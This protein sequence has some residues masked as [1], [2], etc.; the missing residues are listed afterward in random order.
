M[1]LSSE[2]IKAAIAWHYRYDEQCPLVAF[3]ANCRLEPWTGERADLLVVTKDRHLVEVEIKCSIADLRADRKKSKH[4]RFR[5]G[6]GGMPTHLFYFAFRKE[7]ANRALAVCDKL[8]PYAGVWGVSVV[9]GAYSNV[10]GWS[11]FSE[12][13]RRPRVLSQER[14]SI[15]KIVRMSMEQSGTLCRL[16]KLKA[17]AEAGMD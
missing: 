13:Y 1:K 9:K 4:Q 7:I 17:L 14:L 2:V 3:E 16:A 8:F 5:D 12:C 11:F 10:P 6:Y 15:S